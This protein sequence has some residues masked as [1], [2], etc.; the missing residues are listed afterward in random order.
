MENELL[1]LNCKNGHAR[2]GG[3]PYQNEICGSVNLGPASSF[4]VL[5]DSRV[6]TSSRG[7]RIPSS[8]G[9]LRLRLARTEKRL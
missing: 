7:P 2:Q 3:V 9:S 4:V 5:V 8:F 6:L 1:P